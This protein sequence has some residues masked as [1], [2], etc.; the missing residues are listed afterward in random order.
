MG[1]MQRSSVLMLIYKL[2]QV[3]AI[4]SNGDSEI[5]SMTVPA[6]FNSHGLLE[7][8]N[9][10]YPDA[11]TWCN[12]RGE[13]FYTIN[14]NIAAVSTSAKVRHMVALRALMSDGFSFQA[15]SLQLTWQKES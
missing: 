2:A 9:E 1:L 14:R 13:N 10:G 15:Q 5:G 4:A 6:R 8:P 12:K 11:F 3:A 7:H